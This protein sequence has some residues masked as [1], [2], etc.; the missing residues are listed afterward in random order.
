M[1]IKQQ[2]LGLMSTNAY[3]LIDEI[4]GIGALIDCPDNIAPML[5]LI[6]STEE[7]KELKYL[8]LTHGHYDHILGIPEFRKKFNVPVLVCTED[9]ACL[10]SG[11]L[12]L[13]AFA[14]VEQ[15]PCVADQFLKDG[16][17]I[18]LGSLKIKVL[19]TP[20]HTDGS[21]CLI[22]ED[23]IFSGDTVFYGTVGTTALPG[24]DMTV[25]LQSIKKISSLVGD[26]TVYP[27]HD[28]KTT[29]D[30]ERVNNIY[31]KQV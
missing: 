1:I 18:E 21:C 17:V 3:L 11:K 29:L 8:I 22:V 13:A 16:D 23:V 25:L 12:S 10:K 20:G 14:G 6:E 7:L 26:Y 27:G 15:E 24:G 28:K 4:T 2:T 31:F 30:F 19:Q 9:E 5:S